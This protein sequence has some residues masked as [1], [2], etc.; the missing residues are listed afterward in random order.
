M[1]RSITTFFFQFF[2]LLLLLLIPSI[3]NVCVQSPKDTHLKTFYYFDS[4]ET[5]C[6][7]QSGS[8]YEAHRCLCSTKQKNTVVNERLKLKTLMLFST[9]LKV[10]DNHN[11]HY[12]EDEYSDLHSFEP[13]CKI[14]KHFRTYGELVFTYESYKNNSELRRPCNSRDDLSNYIYLPKKLSKAFLRKLLLYVRTADTRTFIVLCSL[15]CTVMILETAVQV[16]IGTHEYTWIIHYLDVI[17]SG[18]ALP[19]N[20]LIVTDDEKEITSDGQQKSICSY[21]YDSGMRQNETVAFNNVITEVK[22]SKIYAK[23]DGSHLV[24]VGGY[25]NKRIQFNSRAE[26]ILESFPHKHVKAVRN[27]RVVTIKDAPFTMIHEHSDH[28]LNLRDLTCNTGN[29]CW[30]YEVHNKTKIRVPYCCIGHSMDLLNKVAVDLDLI[31]DIYIVE[32][33]AFGQVVNGSWVGLVG[34]LVADKADLVVASISIN[35]KRARYVDF[36]APY[37]PGG[38]SVVVKTEQKEQPFFNFEAFE[39]LSVTL[40][41]TVVFITFFSSFILVLMESKCFCHQVNPY[42][43]RESITYV[44]GLL[45]QKDIAGKNPNKPAARA[46]SVM[47]ALVLLVIMSSYTAVLTAIK[48]TNE[49]RLPVSGINDPKMTNPTHDF[50]FGTFANSVFTQMFSESEDPAWN[51]IGSF[52]KAYNYPNP[53]VGFAKLTSGELDAV[54]HD[55]Y[56]SLHYMA[57]DCRLQIAGDIIPEPGFGFALQKGALLTNEI[58]DLFRSYNENDLLKKLEQKWIDRS[59]RDVNG[60]DSGERISQIGITYFGGLFIVVFVWTGLSAC[61]AYAFTFQSGTDLPK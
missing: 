50:K 56:T 28:I 15:E 57:K 53:D 22:G 38:V 8:L 23:S 5:A 42:P 46:V 12:I 47:L 9:W 4:N 43:W 1:H 54:V 44:V 27:I 35:T 41:L 24:L 25:S 2:L 49:S 39:P 21:Y 26:E 19:S 16:G 6:R 37:M 45:F 51:R 20:L 3:Y 61:N 60:G 31:P 11:E 14:S 32:D 59:C 7:I 48:V 29:L 34:E 13:Q 40:W 55:Y 10:E 52:M 30:Q 58:S 33:G 17:P 18:T 36:T